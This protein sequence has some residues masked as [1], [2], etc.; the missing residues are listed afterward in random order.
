MGRSRRQKVSF[1]RVVSRYGEAVPISD[2]SI[3]RLGRSLLRSTSRS[4]SL[5]TLNYPELAR[6]SGGS[7]WAT[8]ARGNRSLTMWDQA[9]GTA[10]EPEHGPSRQSHKKAASASRLGRLFRLGTM[11]NAAATGPRICRRRSAAA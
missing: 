11:S 8:Q 6:R 5:S 10:M 1:Q 2:E 9:G 3:W 7:Q 4:R